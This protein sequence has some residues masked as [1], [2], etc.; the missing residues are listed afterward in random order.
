MRN[1][2]AALHVIGYGGDEIQE[3]GI[4]AMYCTHGKISKTL[5][6]K[7]VLLEPAVHGRIILKWI[8]MNQSVRVN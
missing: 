8:L 7:Q 3:N 5:T 6:M 1:L 4:D 2:H